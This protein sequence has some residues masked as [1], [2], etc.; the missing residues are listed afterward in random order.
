MKLSLLKKKLIL[1]IKNNYKM[2]NILKTC[3]IYYIKMK[4][5]MKK[6]NNLFKKMK[7]YKIKINKF[8]K[9]SFK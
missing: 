6:Y 3:K 7:I 8:F 1:N 5:I 2:I 4:N 9:V